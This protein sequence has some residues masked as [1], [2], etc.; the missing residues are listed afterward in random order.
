MITVRMVVGL[1]LGLNTCV[2]FSCQCGKLVDAKGM[3][4]LSCKL[5]YGRM[6]CHQH[7]NYLIW[8][9]VCKANVPA[10]KEPSGL[11]RSDSKRPDG[12]THI[13]W[14][15]G[16]P[17]TWDVTVINTLADSYISFA[18]V[19]AGHDTELAAERKSAKCSTFPQHIPIPASGA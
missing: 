4:G 19:S 16:K 2:P 9:A 7:C 3:H 5:A 11:V 10:V 18:S 6:A 12:M 13:P 1:R 14:L 15:Q 8:R 17:V